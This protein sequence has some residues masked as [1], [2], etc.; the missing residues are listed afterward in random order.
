MVPNILG[1]LMHTPIQKL[2]SVL[3]VLVETQNYFYMEREVSFL[4]AMIIKV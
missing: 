4:K 2:L 3:T 1:V